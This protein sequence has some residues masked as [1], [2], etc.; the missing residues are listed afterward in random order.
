MSNI[1]SIKELQSKLVEV[2]KNWGSKRNTI[3]GILKE[4]ISD[5]D[6]SIFKLE[7]VGLAFRVIVDLSS[8]LY[9]INYEHCKLS[10]GIS[11]SLIKGWVGMSSNKI[12]L[13]TNPTKEEIIDSFEQQLGKILSGYTLIS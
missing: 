3:S 11:S 1:N 2:R 13:G 9:T 12:D 5:I 6:E 10:G 8:E 4:Y 7:E